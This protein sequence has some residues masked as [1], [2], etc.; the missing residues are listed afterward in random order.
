MTPATLNRVGTALYGPFWQSQLARDLGVND[1]TLRRWVAG[2]M[3][4]PERVREELSDIINNRRQ[5]LSE[6][7]QYLE[8]TDDH[9]TDV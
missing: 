4:I 5:L 6:T 2:D 8:R 9:E 3:Q 1:R 7:L